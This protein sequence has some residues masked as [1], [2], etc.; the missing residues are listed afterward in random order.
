MGAHSSLT[1]TR[2]QA[3]TRLVRE[4]LEVKEAKYRAKAE[5]LSND[6]LEQELDVLL[7]KQL[8]NAVI[9]R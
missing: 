7:D 1:F 4:K 8:Y 6:E 2:E 3:I 9:T 5:R